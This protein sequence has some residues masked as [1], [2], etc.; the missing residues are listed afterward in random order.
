MSQSATRFLQQEN[1]RLHNSVEMLQ[2]ENKTLYSYLEVVKELYW[3]TQQV[4]TEENLIYSLNKLLYTAMSTIQASDGSL[5]RHDGDAGELVFVLAHGDLSQQL[6]GYRIKDNTGIAGWVVENRQPIIV[7][8]PRQDWRF[9]EVVD[10]EFSFFTNSIVS[11]PVM[12]RDR[13]MGV[14]QMLNKRGH[15]FD[16]A[17]VS[18]L[19]MLG[20][21]A[22]IVIEA[23]ES[24]LETGQAD[25][26]DFYY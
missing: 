9:S 7:N 20:L 4:T 18:L 17:D 3:A 14:I 24:R 25:P 19:L 12:R 11:V 8:N 21:V 13:F 23:F 5:S 10:Q 15:Q 26:E 1:T 16:Q 6:P 22:A 2:A